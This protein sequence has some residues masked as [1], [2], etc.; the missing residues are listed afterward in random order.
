MD[1]VTKSFSKGKYHLGC[2]DMERDIIPMSKELN[3]A[4]IPWAVLGQG[5]FTGKNLRGE[6]LQG[7]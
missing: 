6:K 7:R 1:I 2:R 4:V 3:L 5:K